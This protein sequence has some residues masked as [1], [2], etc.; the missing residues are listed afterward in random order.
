MTKIE[1]T[2]VPGFKGETWNPVVG[3]SVIS[4]GCKNCY[5]MRMAA[6]LARI[7]DASGDGEIAAGRYRGLTAPSK[8]GPVWTGK[9]AFAGEIALAKPL[10]WKAPRCVFVNSMGDLFHEAVPDSWID[11]VFAVMTLCPQHIFL[12]LTKRAERMRRYFSDHELY[13]R[14]DWWNAE[15][16]SGE[17][18]DAA[19]SRREEIYGAEHPWP[20]P[21]V[22]LGVSAEDQKRADERIPDLLAT[23]AG[24]RFVSY[25]PALGPVDLSPWLPSAPAAAA[26]ADAAS[27]SKSA[28]GLIQTLDWVIAGGE[29]GPSA[30]PAHPDWFRSIRDQCQRA[31]IPFFFKQWGEYMPA[32]GSAGRFIAD[33]DNHDMARVGKKAAG[34]VLDGRKHLWWPL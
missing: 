30:R 8:A 28:D 17:L 2:Q 13:S 33:P 9:I 7:A 31:N 1:W 15:T 26:P 14:I 20:L 12:V 27:A 21:N 22:W 4:A 34:A 3:C 23:P 6:R 18:Y 19:A 10:K 24:K 25:E 11:R 29:S 5:A 16:C 32:D